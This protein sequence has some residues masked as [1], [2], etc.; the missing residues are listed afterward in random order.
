[1]KR[2]SVARLVVAAGL[3]AAWI[4]YLAFLA[5]TASH[6]VVLSRP[7][8]LVADLWVI[9]DVDVPK[10]SVTMR[11]VAYAA[12]PVRAAAPKDGTTIDVKNL[13]DC[14]AWTGNGRYILPLV[15]D[16]S[17]YRVP[18]IPR[19]PGYGA[20]ATR[21]YPDTPETRDQL[22]EMRDRRTQQ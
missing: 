11:E 20:G 5:V 18:P 17:A 4:A 9:A 15:A 7:Q 21:V 16:G 10:G 3:F 12:P 14:K 2:R 1:M 19:S 22:N 6:P 13:G 8:F